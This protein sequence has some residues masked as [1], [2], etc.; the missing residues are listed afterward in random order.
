M[1]QTLRMKR[2][3]REVVQIGRPA[4]QRLVDGMPWHSAASHSDVEAFRQ[5]QIA[6][7]MKPKEAK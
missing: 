1:S 4:P 6:R 5:R 7:G 2:E 3:L